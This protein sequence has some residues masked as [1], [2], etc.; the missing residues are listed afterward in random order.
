MA[1]KAK[2]GLR[3][4]LG[5]AV[6]YLIPLAISVLLVMWLFRKVDIKEME[7]VI[8]T[9]CD[10]R[11]IALMMLITTLSHIIRGIRWGIQLRGAGI[12]RIP[13]IAESVSIFGAY[14]LN[15]VFPRLG[16][17]WRCMYITRRE[18][19]SFSTV[20]GTD[21]G[22]RASDAVVVLAL[23]G[24]ALI[25]AHPAIDN[26]ITGYKVGEDVARMTHDLWLWLGIGGGILILWAVC[27]FMRRYRYISELDGDLKRVWQG[28]KVLFTMKGAGLYVVLTLGIWTCY[29]LETYV[30]FFAFPF[31]RAL[32][33]EPGTAYGL[34]P[35]L[36]VFVF[37][38]F[39]MAVPSNGGLGPWNLAVMFAL[40]LYAIDDTRGA[41]FSMVMWGC[42]A[43][44]LITLGVFSAVYIALSGA[45]KSQSTSPAG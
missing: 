22:D 10:F 9:E 40:S 41:A 39:S 4:W 21:I 30:C 14:A 27:H 19:T 20:V 26:F 28:F 15:L 42:Q 18:H 8:R 25:V 2:S 31:T 3:T 37:G 24:L 34:I 12:P 43:A 23:L 11:W 29:Y 17:V 36:V 16:E 33:T 44:M 6:R 38:S 32:I 13:V 5:R 35:G 7:R 1:V 45:T